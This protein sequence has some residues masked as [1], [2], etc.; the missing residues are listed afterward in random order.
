MTIPRFLFAV[1]LSVLLTFV[2]LTAYALYP[3]IVLMLRQ[4]SGGPESAGIAAVASG[5]SSSAFLIIESVIFLLC[6][7]ILY[8]K[9]E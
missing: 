5:V 3:A 8:R 4:R 2:I 1:L 6:F 9:R 7:A